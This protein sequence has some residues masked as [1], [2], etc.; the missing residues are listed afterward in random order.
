MPVIECRKCGTANVDVKGLL[1]IKPVGEYAHQSALREVRDAGK[2]HFASFVPVREAGEVE[3]RIHDEKIAHLQRV[4]TS[5]Y[6][7][8]YSGTTREILTE[9]VGG[10][11]DIDVDLYLT[12]DLYRN[13]RGTRRNGAHY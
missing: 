7:G 4:D 8:S 9:I 12:P 10:A 3:V 6:L 5:D 2:W 1:L 13:V 11:D